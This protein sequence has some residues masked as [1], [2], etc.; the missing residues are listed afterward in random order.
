MDFNLY[1]RLMYKEMSSLSDG[2]VFIL[3][4]ELLAQIES[5]PRHPL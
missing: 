2:T 4:I 1:S 5:N 3:K